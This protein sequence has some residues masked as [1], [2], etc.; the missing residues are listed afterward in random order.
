[1]GTTI[2]GTDS[3]GVGNDIGCNGEEAYINAA[4][5]EVNQFV[6]SIAAPAPF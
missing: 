2:Y 4:S 3:I 1:M 6:A 5:E